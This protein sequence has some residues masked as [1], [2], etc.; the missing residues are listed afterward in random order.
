MGTKHIGFCEDE[1]VAKGVVH[2]RLRGKVDDGVDGFAADHIS[3]A[4]R[5]KN[6]RTR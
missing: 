5:E 1:A 4:R 3:S 2:V 6:V